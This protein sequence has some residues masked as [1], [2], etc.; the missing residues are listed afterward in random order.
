MPSTLVPPPNFWQTVRLLLRAARRRAQGRRVRQQQLLHQKTKKQTSWSIG[1]FAVLGSILLSVVLQSLVAASVFEVV[2]ASQRS[3]AEAQG[4]IVVRRTFINMVTRYERVEQDEAAYSA[5]LQE[6]QGRDP[7]ADQIGSAYNKYNQTISTIVHNEAERISKKFG[8]STAQIEDKLWRE[9]REHG[10]ANFVDERQVEK[11]LSEVHATTGLAAMLGSIS[12]LLWLVMM[13]CQGEGMEL[14]LQRRRH[15]M[16][17]WLLAHPVQ[18]AAVFLA[19]MFAPLSANPLYWFGPVYLG[20]LYGMV[21]GLLPGVSAALLAGVPVTLGTACLGKALEIGVMIRFSPRTRGAV[22]GI[23]SWLGYATLMFSFVGFYILPRFIMATGK[24]LAPLGEI[25]WPWLQLVLGGV[26]GQRY[27]FA[28]GIATCWMLSLLMIAAGVGFSLWG[29]KKGLSYEYD[30]FGNALVTT[31]STPNVYLYRGEAWD[32]DL[33]LYYLRARWYNP[34]TGRFVSQDP[35]NGI[36][37]DP[38]TLHKYVYANGDPVNLMDPTGRAAATATWGGGGS[39]G[40][41]AMLLGAITLTTQPAL[42]ALGKAIACVYSTIADTLGEIAEGKI[43]IPEPSECTAE[44]KCRPCDPPVGTQ[45]CRI[46]T[47]GPSHK[48]N[49]IPIPVPHWHLYEMNQNPNNCQCFWVPVPDNKGGFGA[50]PPP[51]GIGP[52]GPAGGGGPW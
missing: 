33:G 18:P 23:L 6:E 16:W 40:E 39:L 9:I 36:I 7:Y 3:E 26:I 1:A 44:G 28:L 30:A 27:N 5:R 50:C 37:T 12:L 46:D 45:Q 11:G 13:I 21:Y 47:T 15:P 20:V 17:E 4:K 43:P 34:V 25:G 29:T 31:G 32:S 14:D 41:Y 10:G 38:K 24:F 42:K 8:G 52:I 2:Q 19:E 49:G 51:P 48:L 35:E 22:L